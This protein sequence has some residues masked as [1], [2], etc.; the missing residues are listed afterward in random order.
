MTKR[1]ITKTPKRK[2]KPYFSFLIIIFLIITFNLLNNSKIKITDQQLVFYLLESSKFKESDKN[3]YKYVKRKII[4]I[5]EEPTNY[6][7]INSN[8]IS[9]PKTQQVIKKE[10]QTTIQ[11]P[12]IYIYNS[13]QTEEY[14]SSTFLEYTI[15]P[16]VMISNYILEEQFK[17][18]GYQ[19]IVEEESIKK[20]LNNNS[21]N[22]SYS[23][24]AS[25][26]LLE[27]AKKSNPTLKYFID[28]HRDSLPKERTTIEI[29]DKSYAKI[30]FI[31]G[32]ENPNYQENLTFTEKINAKI[33][34]KYPN[35]S[36]GIYKKSGPGV[37]GIYNQD[38]SPYTILVE[39]GG[40]QNTPTE[41]M[42]SSLAF[43]ECYLEVIN[44]Y[45]TT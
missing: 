9:T 21:W 39:M 5:Y 43:A 6:L 19:S 24:K 7:N 32:L 44:S 26:I 8:I 38:F 18:Q 42:N 28:V 15:N 1:F 34:E 4:N 27:Q 40:Y 12:K 29:N 10:P 33:N 25:R 23:Y 30:L 17:S 16:T 13:H 11:N 41:V 31:I 37:N 3:I 35:L 20:I 36:K 14:A 22:Y 45:E 2:I